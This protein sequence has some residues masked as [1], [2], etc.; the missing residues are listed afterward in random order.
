MN[1]LDQQ[2]SSLI[3]KLYVEAI[4]PYMVEENKVVYFIDPVFHISRNRVIAETLNAILRLNLEPD[5]RLIQKLF[6][7]LVTTQHNNGSWNEVHPHYNHPSA[8]ITSIVADTFLLAIE[9]GKDLDFFPSVIDKAKEFLLHQ[10]IKPGYFLK[11]AN[12]TADHLNVDATCGSFLSHYAHLF[13]D[14]NT[15]EVSKRVSDHII[16]HQWKNG[17]YPYAID[18]GT[19][20]YIKEVPCIHYQGVTLYYLS[21]IHTYTQE[22]SLLESILTGGN[23]LAQVQQDDGWFDWSKSGLLFTYYVIGAYGFALSSFS[24]LSQFNDH[25]ESNANKCLPILKSHQRSL[26]VRWEQSNWI[27]FPNSIFESIET[28]KKAKARIDIIFTR[29]LYALY[30]QIARRRYADT[31][32]TTFFNVLVSVLH[33]KVS[34]VEPFSNYPDLFMTTEIINCLSSICNS[35]G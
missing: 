20:T 31:I 10:E 12:Y 11:S 32:D 27:S 24:Y 18:K 14:E 6:H 2:I 30:R 19:Y 3:L 34:T 35:S 9:K 25:F 21:R 26:F 16:A 28:A 4:K 17:V 23:W 5:D 29:L 15:L 7:Y 22:D 13:E 33:L 8:L 1:K